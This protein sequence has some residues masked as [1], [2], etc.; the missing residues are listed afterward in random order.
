[1]RILRFV[2]KFVLPRRGGGILPSSGALLG[3]IILWVVL[4][5]GWGGG[6]AWAADILLMPSAEQVGTGEQKISLSLVNP[7]EAGVGDLTLYE[8][9]YGLSDSVEISWI[10][11][12]QTGAEDSK[13]FN[14]SYLVVPETQDNWA[15]AVGVVNVG[16]D[17]YFGGDD[18]S[19]YLAFYRTQEQGRSARGGQKNVP[20][21]RYHLGYGTKSHDGFFGGLQIMT[22]SRMWIGG[23][24]YTGRPTYLV[25]YTLREK[26]G[27]KVSLRGG[28]LGG[29]PW[30]G[31]SYGTALGM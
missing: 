17:R 6:M 8:V 7:R 18:R 15:T 26:V 29:D 22:S 25:D 1:M 11:G 19:Y 14:I 2:S 23:F 10:K 3:A 4:A 9:Y 24:S 20:G 30:F 27:S 16:G 12:N 31:V 28:Y 5:S 21:Y 13:A